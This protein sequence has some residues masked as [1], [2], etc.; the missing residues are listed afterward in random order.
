[1]KTQITIIGNI[2]GDPELRVTP[3]GD[4]VASFSVAV[5]DRVKDKRSGEWADGETTWYRVSAWR[6]LGENAAECLQRGQRVTVVG[7]VKA[8]TW[9]DKEGNERTTFAV[10]ADDIAISVRFTTLYPAE[11][12]APPTR[13]AA[14]L[15]PGEEPF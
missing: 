6:D 14:P 1:M 7:S 10:E 9:T 8:E 5:T 11:S 3:A 12:K 4:S 13:T 2:G 15:A